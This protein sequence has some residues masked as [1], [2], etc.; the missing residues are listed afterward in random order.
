MTV[1]TT[2]SKKPPARKKAAAASRKKTPARPGK[3]KATAKGKGRPN[4]AP[5]RPAALT[6]KELNYARERYALGE[7]LRVIAEQLGCSHETLRTYQTR[8]R[9]RKDL[10]NIPQGLK[11]A[12]EIARER[13]F[14]PLDDLVQHIQALD[15]G[16]D[17]LMADIEYGLVRDHDIA[18][19]LARVI[20]ARGLTAEW[21]MK[22]L[23]YFH[24]RR[25]AVGGAVDLRFTSLV[26]ALDSIDGR[27][28]GIPSIPDDAQG[29]D[30]E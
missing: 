20:E 10:T 23:P 19:V 2:P 29:F 15:A 17:E 22:V 4:R 18:E 24:A 27:T 21:R 26:D 30:D 25:T 3:K 16:A 11:S 12:E 7:P 28:S 8:R 13:G 5:R 1:R 9:W 6:D 14:D